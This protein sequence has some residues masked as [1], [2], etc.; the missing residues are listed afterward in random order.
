[1]IDQRAKRLLWICVLTA[2]GCL[3]ANE[4]AA[5]GGGVDA[6]EPPSDVLQ[7]SIPSPSGQH[8]EWLS[9][10]HDLN[11]TRSAPLEWRLNARNA[12]RLGVKW[13]FKTGGDMWAT[14]AVDETTVYVPDAK[15]SLFAIDRRTGTARWTGKIPD[16]TGGGPDTVS[17]TTPAIY[18]N[19]LYLGDARGSD[20]T[21]VFAVDKRTGA[22]LWSTRVETHPAARIVMSPVV[23]GDA[24]YLGVSS[25]EESWAAS[26]RGYRC[27]TFRGSVIALD[28]H[29]GRLLWQTF[30][31][32]GD[33][34]PGYAGGAVWGST[35]VVD[36]KRGSLY[37]TTGNDYTVP[38]AILD[39][40][41]LPTPEEVAAC[42]REVPGSEDNH[43]DSIVSLDLQT[44]RIKWA[45]AMI[46][47]DS[48]NTSC[49]FAVPGN[50]TNCT[51]PH[52]EDYDF[53][54]GPILYTAS[55]DGRRR[56]LLGAGQKSGVFWAVDPDDGEVVWSTEVGPGGSLGGMEWGSAYDGRRIY[57]AVA[58]SAGK[59][60]QLPSGETTRA[61]F[62]AAL[63][64]ATGKILWQ[65]RGA[66][67]VTS[68]SRGAVSVA[69][70]VVFGGTMSRAGTLYALDAATG[71]T[72]WTFASGGSIITAPAVVDGDVYWGSGYG[73]ATSTLGLQGNNVLYAFAV[74]GRG[75]PGDAGIDAGP[76]AGPSRDATVAEDGGSDAAVAEDAGSDATAPDDGGSDAAVPEDGGSDAT[77]PD[78]GGVAVPTW[79]TLYQTYLGEG[80]V[81]HCQNCHLQMGSKSEA[82]AWLVDV[83]QID[84]VASKLVIPGQSRLTWFGGGMPIG[85]PRSYPEAEAGLTAWVAAG[86]RD[87]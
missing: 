27:C 74:G 58:N 83:G 66:P 38:T 44:G 26:T 40:Q 73:F 36:T 65:T 51:Q 18:G 47:F 34:A 59:S 32:P 52:G 23:Y 48:W 49:V 8:S 6:K 86:A 87:D 45:R 53:G 1:V 11:N 2:A 71:A 4:E 7:R 69:G 9:A 16:Y 84:G 41:S 10:G 62:W 25:S 77:A 31:V 29:D 78:E 13:T 39:C 64:P 50:E 3:A 43:F 24:V 72:L 82:Y 68:S 76:D 17:R 19:A 15:G 33:E 14:P 56:E 70:G 30:M 20:G 28:R 80:T 22:K 55:I 54:Q 85:G 12:S 35:P 79:T 63:D 5:R 75:G 67:A 46:P 61:G 21:S 37:V 60:W 42:V 81:G 57:T